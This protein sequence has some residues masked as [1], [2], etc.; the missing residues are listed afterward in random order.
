MRIVNKVKFL[1]TISILV[2]II[3]AFLIFSN[4]TYSKGEIKYRE[5]YIYSGDTLWSIAQNEIENNKYFENKD[6]RYVMNELKNI[7]NFSNYELYD[8]QKIKIPIYK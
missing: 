6:I 7:N 4:N 5:D 3:V 1:R 2:I 8:G